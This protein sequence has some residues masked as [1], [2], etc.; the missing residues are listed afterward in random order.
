PRRGPH[1]SRRD[2]S[3]LAMTEA[4]LRPAPDLHRLGRVGRVEPVRP[5]PPA[6]RQNTACLAGRPA[7]RPGPLTLPGPNADQASREQAPAPQ[8]FPHCRYMV[9]DSCLSDNCLWYKCLRQGSLPC[10]ATLQKKFGAVVRRRRE[11]A[12]LSQEALA[13]AA[14]LHRT[15]ISL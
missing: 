3:F 9:A 4:R 7:A 12:E 2:F 13:D 1:G 15:Y 6:G 8:Q 10:V 5:Q 14:G 11:G